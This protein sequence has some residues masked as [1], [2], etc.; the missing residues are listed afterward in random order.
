[1]DIATIMRKLMGLWIIGAV[2][3]GGAGVD[4]ASRRWGWR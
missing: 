2:S 4:G 1:M 3:G